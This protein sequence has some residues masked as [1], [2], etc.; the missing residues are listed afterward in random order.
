MILRFYR[1]SRLSGAKQLEGHIDAYI[2]AYNDKAE[3]FV[4]TKK[5]VRQRR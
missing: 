5:K 1:D 3:S 4:W 2:K